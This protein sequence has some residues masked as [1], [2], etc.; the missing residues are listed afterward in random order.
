M[1]LHGPHALSAFKVRQLL[2]LL[3]P[4]FPSLTAIEARYLHYLDVSAP[5]SASQRRTLDALL[6]YGAASAESMGDSDSQ[7]RKHN[8]A[9]CATIVVPRQ[10]PFPLVQQGNRHCSRLRTDHR[11]KGRTRYRMA[12]CRVG[13]CRRGRAGPVCT[14]LRQRDR[15]AA[16]LDIGATLFATDAPRP[17]VHIGRVASL[18]ADLLSANAELGLGLSDVELD[19]LVRAYNDLGRPPTDVEL[20]MFAQVNSE[21]CRHKIFN[22]AWT[23]DGARHNTSLFDMIRH[24]HA[25]IPAACYPPT[26]TTPP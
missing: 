22:A 10:A 3:A 20:M 5:L 24:T 21:H 23:I 1:L 12:L 6:D 9:W 4:H 8:P 13:Q 14:H 16:D 17:L 25:T 19:Y 7:A 18:D 2:Q 11:T 15:G 26:V